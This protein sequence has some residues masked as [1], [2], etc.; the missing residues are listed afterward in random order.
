MTSPI[1]RS[2]S[3]KFGETVTW[4]TELFAIDRRTAT[5]LVWEKCVRI[6]TDQHYY[7]DADIA[8]KFLANFK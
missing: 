1:H 3:A 6:G 2:P 5:H 8:R 7:I 4:L